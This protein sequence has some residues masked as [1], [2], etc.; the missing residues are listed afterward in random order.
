MQCKLENVTVDALLR[1]EDITVDSFGPQELSGRKAFYSQGIFGQGE[2]AAVIDSGVNPNH[3]ELVGRVLAGKNCITNYNTSWHDDN[4][5][6]THVASLVAGKNC[7]I[8]PMAEILPI[9]VTDAMG[10]SQWKYIIAGIDYARNWRG[11]NGK[12]VTV[13]S[14]SL[15]SAESGITTTEKKNLEKAID[16]CVDEDILVVCSAGNT[17]KEEKRYPA[18]LENVV[19]VGAVDVKKKI[20]QFST[21]G[22]H[23][24]LCQVGVN[25]VG[26]Y[27]DQSQGYSYI[28]L[29]GTSFST[30][31]TTGIALLVACAHKLRYK[32]RITER[33]LYEAL[34]M[35]SKDLGIPGVDKYYGAGFCT[36]QPLNLSIEVENDSDIVI[37]NGE[38]IKLDV[39]IKI[40]N[41][42]TMFP[43][44]EFAE[45]T[46]AKVGWT[47]PG[48]PN[49]KTK[50]RYDW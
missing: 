49:Y 40:I 5:H 9:K 36:L 17:S 6:G 44:R 32:E 19:C 18:S 7:G 15:S 29:S 41:D 39:P 8:A 27:Y 24:D 30:P 13:I 45:R 25:I 2:V 31:I 3:V 28:E 33:K 37:F 48:P 16:N 20:A 50:S 10:G 47:P 22:N 1:Q 26:A 14:M 38:P 4:K 21:S 42:R 12:R 23:V 34:K 35:Y 46:G 11:P 43:I